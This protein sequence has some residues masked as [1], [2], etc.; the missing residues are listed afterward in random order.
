[1]LGRRFDDYPV[2]LLGILIAI[3]ASFVRILADRAE[4]PEPARATPISVGCAGEMWVG[5]LTRRPE[6]YPHHNISLD[7]L[8]TRSASC[9]HSLLS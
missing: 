1:M 5:C 8:R 4:S 3:D 7:Y 9:R 2:S 6:C